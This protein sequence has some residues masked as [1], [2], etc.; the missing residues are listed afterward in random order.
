M[1]D[2]SFFSSFFVCFFQFLCI[3][4]QNIFWLSAYCESVSC[5]LVIV[6][7]HFD[8]FLLSFCEFWVL[9]EASSKERFLNSNLGA[10]ESSK[11]SD[12]GRSCK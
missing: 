1:A 7:P 8:D 4:L 6:S 2:F 3:I 11:S 9:Q 12:C 10:E 5:C